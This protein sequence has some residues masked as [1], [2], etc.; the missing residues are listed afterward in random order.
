[1]EHR[2]TRYSLDLGYSTNSKRRWRRYRL[3]Y[4]AFFSILVFFLLTV[5]ATSAAQPQEYFF[6]NLSEK[7]YET[8]AREEPVIRAVS[9]AKKISL[10]LSDEAA[11]EIR[12]RI[13]AI[14]PN[15]L[16]E[17]MLSIAVKDNQEAAVLLNR[18]A[19]ALSDV[20]GYVKIPYWSKQQRTF[21]DLFD[22][23]QVLGRTSIDGGESIDVLQHMEPFDDY[24]ARYSY[25]QEKDSL[26]FSCSNVGEIVYS[27]R[28]FAAV[29]SGDMLWELYAFRHGDRL[30]I[31]GIGAVKAFDFMGL[32]RDRLEP[33]FMGR[34]EAFF[35]H[36]AK[37]IQR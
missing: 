1:M 13:S 22:K 11:D 4:F 3:K 2:L 36:I 10:T 5:Q 19:T 6:Q 18:V 30:E 29:A 7:E 25:Q 34:V 21:Y 16:T 12:N 24:K 17:L 14:K 31:Y 23:M 27:Y 15:Y 8:L 37:K 32:F 26:R 33:S 28:N 35:L 20:E 9:N